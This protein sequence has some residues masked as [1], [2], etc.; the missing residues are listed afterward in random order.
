MPT[1]Q[2]DSFLITPNPVNRGFD[3]G[4]H[5]ADDFAVGVDGDALHDALQTWPSWNE[6]CLAVLKPGSIKASF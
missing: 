3:F 5:A 1:N 2:T 4:F 6:A